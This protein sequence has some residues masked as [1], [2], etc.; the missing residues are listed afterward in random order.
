[1]K[2]ALEA[3]CGLALPADVVIDNEKRIAC[4]RHILE[5]KIAQ[6][7]VEV[8]VETKVVNIPCTVDR[9]SL[10]NKLQISHN[11]KIKAKIEKLIVRALE[12][13]K[14]KIAYRLSVI[15]SKDGDFVMV[16]GQRFSSRVLRVNLEGTSKVVPFVL[17]CGTEIE[18]WANSHNTMFEKLCI[19]RIMEAVLRSAG[20]RIFPQIDKE[21]NI[22]YAA[23][24][25][26]GSLP[27]WP[28]S[29]QKPLFRL[30]GNLEEL[31]GVKLHDSFVMSPKKTVSGFR[32]TN[33]DGYVDCQL[34]LKEACPDR[35]APYETYLYQEKYQER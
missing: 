14:P 34:C 8:K 35:E 19:D 2:K 9:N 15:D 7:A 28:F 29:E 17:T 11:E 21:L 20:H 27:Y 4:Q 12:I 18:E 31:I 5:L 10:F 22:N 23:Y 33:K 1:M 16:E 13:G 24:M 6:K 26:P 3:A 30:L 32:F 25:N